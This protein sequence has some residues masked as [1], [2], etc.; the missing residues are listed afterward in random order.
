LF[1]RVAL[2]SRPRSSQALLLERLGDDAAIRARLEAAQPSEQLRPPPPPAPTAPSLPAP[3]PPPPPLPPPP[4]FAPPVRLAEAEAF[5]QQLAPPPERERGEQRALA[6]R[7][8]ALERA[9]A[10]RLRTREREAARQ[11]EA[12]RARQRE[13][14][15]A[16]RSESDSEEAERSAR[17]MG[18][19][20]QQAAEARARAR[21]ARRRGDAAAREERRRRRAREIEEDAAERRREEAEAQRREE[22]ANRDEAQRAEQ[23]AALAH[24]AQAQ[25]Q[26]AQAAAEAEAAQPPPAA[27]GLPGSLALGSLRRAAPKKAGAPPDGL[28]A[29]AEEAPLSRPLVPLEYSEEELKAALVNEYAAEEAPQEGGGKD[30]RRAREKEERDAKRSTLQLIASIPTERAQLFAYPLDWALFD[31]AQL[32]PVVQRWAAKKVAELLGEAEPSL[33]DFIVQ[34]TSAHC[35]PEALLAELQPVLDEEAEAFCIKL[36][37]LLLF[38]LLKLEKEGGARGT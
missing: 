37:R 38:E 29:E 24:Q 11:R 20:A 18:L 30:A 22:E 28:R 26:A 19:S 12:L 23:A 8:R 27:P 36:W 25:A 10:D 6:D 5:L 35:A 7:E 15:R 33:V 9:E 31:R 14:E 1:L 17:Q 21:Y 34:Q 13:L 3:P 32:A 4:A 16:L 2:S